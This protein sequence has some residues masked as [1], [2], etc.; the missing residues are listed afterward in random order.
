MGS[1]QQEG[2]QIGSRSRFTTTVQIGS[3]SY[4][5]DELKAVVESIEGEERYLGAISLQPAAFADIRKHGPKV[6]DIDFWPTDGAK[7]A[8]S[9]DFHEGQYSFYNLWS[10]GSETSA[11]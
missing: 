3:G 11:E 10:C 4:L 5:L 1:N 6:L 9:T 2:A 8:P 7:R